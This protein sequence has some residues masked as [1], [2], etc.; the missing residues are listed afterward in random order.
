V[1]PTPSPQKEKA[2]KK[3]EKPPIHETAAIVQKDLSPMLAK[4]VIDIRRAMAQRDLTLAKKLL[5]SAQRDT[6]NDADRA[7][8][9][10]LEM[11]LDQLVQFWD[12]IQAAI[13]KLQA[14]EEIVIK[15]TRMVVVDSGPD[16]ISVKV[17][18]KVHRFQ[19][20]TMP[21]SLVMALVDRYFGKDTGSLAIIGTFLAID[22]SGDRALAR[23]YWIDASEDGIDTDKLLPELDVIP[24]ATHRRISND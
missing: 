5:Q 10:R 23:R 20:K 21:T 4:E 1:K 17:E 9:D 16:F 24:P 6:K 12:G 11:M 13:S 22:P 18:G 3:E 19:R 8:T 15:N 2:K 7:E 14:A